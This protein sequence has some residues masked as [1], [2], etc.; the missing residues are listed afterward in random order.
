MKTYPPKLVTVL[1]D[2]FPEAAH[3]DRIG[4]GGESDNDVW[5]Y[6]KNNDYILVS[7]DF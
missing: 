2:V 1:A 6:A 7:K 3:V 5:D 4:L